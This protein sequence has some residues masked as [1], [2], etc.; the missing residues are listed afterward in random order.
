MV[1]GIITVAFGI[2]KS[3]LRNISLRSIV[4]RPCKK[5]SAFMPQN[6]NLRT[7][8]LKTSRVYC[9]KRR[10]HTGS[11]QSQHSL[12]RDLHMVVPASLL[13]IFILIVTLSTH[14]VYSFVQGTGP[15][16]QL[17]VPDPGTLSQLI[18]RNTNLL[19]TFKCTFFFLGH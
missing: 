13:F 9:S 2:V 11:F 18:I 14:V 7:V 5:I 4:V 10:D 12:K 15:S 3:I 8:L 19:Q 17:L 6:M 16:H 1:R